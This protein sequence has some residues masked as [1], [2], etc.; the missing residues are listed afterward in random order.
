MKSIAFNINNYLLTS[1]NFFKDARNFI[2]FDNRLHSLISTIITTYRI[3][4]RFQKLG[5][6]DDFDFKFIDQGYVKNKLTGEFFAVGVKPHDFDDEENIFMDFG[7]NFARETEMEENNVQLEMEYL[8]E[9]IFINPLSS[10][11]PKIY[12]R[13]SAPTTDE[14]KVMGIPIR[15]STGSEKY[16]PRPYVWAKDIFKRSETRI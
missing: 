4:A 1:E 8:C 13:E 16:K 14:I 11:N 2:M 7:L 5:N 6:L 12:L 10:K 9:E 15:M 3:R